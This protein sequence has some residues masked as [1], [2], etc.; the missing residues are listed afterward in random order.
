[1]NQWY[2]ISCGV[3]LSGIGIN[4]VICSL[5]IGR[6]SSI[7]IS[8]KPYPF[9]M[10]QRCRKWD[11]LTSNIFLSLWVL[12]SVNYSAIANAYHK[13]MF[14]GNFCVLYSHESTGD[15]TTCSI[16]IYKVKR[17]SFYVYVKTLHHY[18]NFICRVHTMIVNMLLLHLPRIFNI[19]EVRILWKIDSSNIWWH[20]DIAEEKVKI[21]Q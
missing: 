3:N 19:F 13:N 20:H 12:K 6:R 14:S 18:N 2:A 15:C 1:M 21:C 8:P 5:Q 11:D 9:D 10:E 17:M 4:A 16:V 7:I